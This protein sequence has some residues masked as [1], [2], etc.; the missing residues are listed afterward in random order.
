MDFS[1]GKKF[2]WEERPQNLKVLEDHLAELFL[3]ELLLVFWDSRLG[4]KICAC[5]PLAVLDDLISRY[6]GAHIEQW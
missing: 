4:V 2:T 1:E 6:D 3:D 5:R